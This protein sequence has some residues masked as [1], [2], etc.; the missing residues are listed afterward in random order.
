MSTPDFVYIAGDATKTPVNF[1]TQPK[2]T[3]LVFVSRGKEYPWNR[4]P[5]PVRLVYLASDDA[6]T[7]LTIEDVAQLAPD[8]DIIVENNGR[9]FRT[10][11]GTVHLPAP[12]TLDVLSKW[13]RMNHSDRGGS[14]KPRDPS[15]F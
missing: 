3:P 6:K 11:A 4:R 2:G 8:T 14:N 7:P 12:V 15:S 9:P 13:V 1:S 10:K 5:S